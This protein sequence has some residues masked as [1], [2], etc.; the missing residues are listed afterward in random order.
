LWILKHSFINV[1]LNL[2][3][4]N[5][6]S[7]RTKDFYHFA[8]GEMLMLLFRY[9]CYYLTWWDPRFWIY[10]D[11][12]TGDSSYKST[13]IYGCYWIIVM[14]NETTNIRTEDNIDQL[15]RPES[16]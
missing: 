10:W 12:N 6:Y 5:F 3:V 2:C 11:V 8:G 15:Q 7:G 14:I 9:R 16:L 4:N 13:Y 1:Y